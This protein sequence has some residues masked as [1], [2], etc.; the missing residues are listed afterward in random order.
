M[1]GKKK[2]KETENGNK[3]TVIKNKSLPGVQARRRFFNS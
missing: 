3:R 2:E 1:K